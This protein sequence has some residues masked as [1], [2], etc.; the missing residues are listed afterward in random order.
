MDSISIGKETVSPRFLESH[1]QG[2]S[3]VSVVGWLVV[4]LNH[5]IIEVAA[6]KCVWTSYRFRIGIFSGSNASET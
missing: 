3:I 6:I 1:V 2:G 4:L 5:R